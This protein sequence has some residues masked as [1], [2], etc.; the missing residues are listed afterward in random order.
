MLTAAVGY[1]AYAVLWAVMWVPVHAGG[2]GSLALYPLYLLAWLPIE[3]LVLLSLV[4]SVIDLAVER[5]MLAVTIG[6]TIASGAFLVLSLPTLW[7]GEFPW[8][9][10]LPG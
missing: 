3:C 4:L 5:S 1:G 7:Y 9:V 6:V 10:L 2:T 8:Y